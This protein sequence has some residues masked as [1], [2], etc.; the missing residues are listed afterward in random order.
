MVLY[1]SWL[2]KMNSVENNPERNKNLPKDAE[3]IIAVLQD[4]GVT[5]YEPKVVHQ[6]LEFTYRY[7]SEVLDEAKVYANHAGRSNIN[8]D[9]TKLAVMSQLDNSFTNPPPRDFLVDVARQKN[10]IALPLVKNYSAARLPPDRYCLL[11]V[12]YRLKGSADKKNVRKN[13]TKYLTTS[14]QKH[15]FANPQVIMPSTNAKRKWHEIG[16]YDT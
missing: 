16:N 13:S 10:T 14:T 6:L 1:F 4:M 8:V 11:S 12:N 5:E 15:L 2:V 3:T 9:D 7:I